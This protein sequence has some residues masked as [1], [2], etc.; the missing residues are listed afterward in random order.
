MKV[1]EPGSDHAELTAN[2]FWCPQ[3]RWTNTVG[4][5]PEIPEDG[6]VTSVNF[7]LFVVVAM[8]PYGDVVGQK[9]IRREARC[10]FCSRRRHS[11]D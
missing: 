4:L 1:V 3:K 2:R 10:P 8:Q 11:H 5:A 7:N 9:L 6:S